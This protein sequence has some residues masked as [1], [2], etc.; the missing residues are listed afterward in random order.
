MN[1]RCK[2]GDLA[3]VVSTKSTS[4]ML[5]RVVHVVRPWD[6]GERTSGVNW[7]STDH[8]PMWVIKSASGG[9]LPVRHFD[10]PE[11]PYPDFAL[12]PIRPNEGEDESLSWA[13]KPP[14]KINKIE[15]SNVFTN[16]ESGNASKI[17]QPA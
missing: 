12:R 17:K 8:G 14:S 2:P 5:G 3:I 16:C 6:H 9:G 15:R 10:V 13:E 4:R 11:R 7:D 1:T